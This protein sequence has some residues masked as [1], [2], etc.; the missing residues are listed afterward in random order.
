MLPKLQQRNEGTRQED[1]Q[2]VEVGTK[3]PAIRE[4][5]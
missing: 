5:T 2:F 1:N 3:S 4:Q